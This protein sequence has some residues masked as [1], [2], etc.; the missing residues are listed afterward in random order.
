MRL[1]RTIKRA[2]IITIAGAATL[3][4]SGAPASAH[5]IIVDPPGSEEKVGWVG[6]GPL[7]EA[8]NG[9]GL[10]IGGPSGEYLQPP[11]HGKG[12]NTACAALRANGNGVVNIFGPPSP[13]GCAHGT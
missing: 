7:P 11:S 2:S 13:A 6:G 10:I 4:L 1:G 3:A 9:K 8:A 5:L 12:L